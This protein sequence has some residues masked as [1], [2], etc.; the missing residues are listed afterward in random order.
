MNDAVPHPSQHD[1]EEREVILVIEEDV[2]SSVILADALEHKGPYHPVVSSSF[3]LAV[4]TV[5]LIKPSLVILDS[6][7]SNGNSLD[8]YDQ[9]RAS[10][11]LEAT[12]VVFLTPVNEQ[13]R[14]DLGRRGFVVLDK[15]V[16]LDVLLHTVKRMLH[17]S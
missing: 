6:S 7:F 9:L 3:P 8:F 14:P 13:H 12:P 15:P 5:K 1:Q 17:S 11:E 2:E 4:E 16:D 10:G